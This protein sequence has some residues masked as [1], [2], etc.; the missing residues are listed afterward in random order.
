M[1]S[2]A[3]KTGTEDARLTGWRA[4]GTTVLVCGLSPWVFG[5]LGFALSVPV[6][7]ASL[8]VLPRFRLPAVGG[9]LGWGVWLHDYDYLLNP[10]GPQTPLSRA[11]CE[12]LGVPPSA[13]TA[14]VVAPLLA[15]IG[16]GCAIGC[17]GLLGRHGIKARR[18]GHVPHEGPG[19]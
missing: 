6:A 7:L 17:L 12:R 9:L 8:L 1:N 5:C 14:T 19:K 13:E 15:L 10:G 2:M 3:N 11:I 4:V 18:R 16:A